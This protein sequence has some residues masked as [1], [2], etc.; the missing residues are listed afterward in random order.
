MQG[1]FF[2]K[3]KWSIT[4]KWEAKIQDMYKKADFKYAVLAKNEEKRASKN[5]EYALERVEKKKRSYIRKKEE[6]YRRKMLNEIREYEWKPKK[7]Y[8]SDAPKIKPIQFAMEIAQ[9]NARLR[10]SD[11]DWNGDC[12]SCDIYCSWWN[13]CG[14]H[15]YARTI[16]WTCLELEN[17]NLQ[18]NNCNWITWPKGNTAE[19]EKVNQ[20]YD[21]NLDKKYW[22]WTAEK[23][24]NKVVAYFHGKSTDYDLD[25]E[26]PRLIDE[27]EELWKT[28]NFYAP[29]R[30]WRAIWIKYKNRT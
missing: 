19:K 5:L 2:M 6:E 17:I 9:E 1:F 20:H 25:K 13:H 12:I 23:L 28:K 16:K 30:K 18:C 26:I 10:D 24:K 29:R 14:W 11:A 22:K 3:D 21:E 15:R 8:K 7:E 27:N 4:K